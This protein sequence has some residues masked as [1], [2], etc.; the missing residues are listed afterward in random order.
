[1]R[2]SKKA[3]LWMRL[4]RQKG[5]SFMPIPKSTLQHFRL[6]DLLKFRQLNRSSR[7]LID[8]IL[9]SKYRKIY[10]KSTSTEIRHIILELKRALWPP[11]IK[12]KSR[13]L[14]DYFGNDDWS[15]KSKIEILKANLDWLDN[16]TKE[17]LNNITDM[18][19]D[20]YLESIND[21]CPEYWKQIDDEL[22]TIDPD[23]I[24]NW[25]VHFHNDSKI[26]K[27][28]HKQEYTQLDHAIYT[29]H[30]W[31]GEDMATEITSLNNVK[32]GKELIKLLFDEDDNFHPI[33]DQF[34]P[35]GSE[36]DAL[37]NFLIRL[38]L[39]ID[40][41]LPTL[42]T[43]HIGV[44]VASNPIFKVGDYF[45]YYFFHYES[46]QYYGVGAVG[47]DI[48]EHKKVPIFD[49]E[50]RP[51]LEWTDWLKNQFERLEVDYQ[52]PEEKIMEY[53]KE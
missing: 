22:T 4:V 39:E 35:Q 17:E 38:L 21:Q 53:F 9:T 47:Y 19:L 13:F 8:E 50:G 30:D 3:K 5:G 46:R 1:M 49:G 40:L 2:Y 51:D 34:D 29:I 18:F 24:K 11:Y 43:R 33:R 32:N 16:L 26:Y 37:E 52:L 48:R 28:L 45:N 23:W 7:A 36:P 31:Y 42:L 44:V 12:K 25:R 10:P 41:D 14:T 20:Q 15:G 27:I 6:I